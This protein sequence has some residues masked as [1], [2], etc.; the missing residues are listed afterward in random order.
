[1]LLNRQTSPPYHMTTSLTYSGSMK[2]VVL[3]LLTFLTAAC[4]SDI[5]VRD[6]VTDGN[7]FYI[8]SS[9]LLDDDPV[10]QS[11]VAYSAAKSVCQ[12]E[13]GGA[14]PARASSYGC[15]LSSRIILLDTWE[16]LLAENPKLDNDYLTTLAT[17][18]D[19][20]FLDEYVVHYY[21]KKNWSVPAEVDSDGFNTWRR[22]HLKN[23][24]PYTRIVGSWVRSTP[25]R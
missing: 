20:A 6:G 5:Y 13:L 1:M 4:Q 16:Q 18:R 12:L 14:N 8:S 10:V 22:Q 11:W 23:H 25:N 17:V 2:R 7:K 21:A 9:A 3:L 24:E 19:A 15:E